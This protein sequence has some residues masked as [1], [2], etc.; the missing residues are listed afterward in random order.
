[1]HFFLNKPISESAKKDLQDYTSIY[2]NSK[3]ENF[4]F[5]DEKCPL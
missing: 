3:N 2:I 4:D 1:M 5:G